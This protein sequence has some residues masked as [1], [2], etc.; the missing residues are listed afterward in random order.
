MYIVQVGR[1]CDKISK[2]FRDYFLLSIAAIRATSDVIV[3]ELIA[4][5]NK[6][7]PQCVL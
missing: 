4:Y 3:L 1:N 2:Q 7:M 6:E 5:R